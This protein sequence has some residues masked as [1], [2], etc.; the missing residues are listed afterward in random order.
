MKQLTKQEKAVLCANHGWKCCRLD[1][2]G[3]YIVA[4]ENEPNNPE[5][6]GKYINALLFDDYDFEQ[7]LAIY[8][9]E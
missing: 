2:D 7:E 9:G 4:I 8:E 5:N 3:I 6:Y 1:S